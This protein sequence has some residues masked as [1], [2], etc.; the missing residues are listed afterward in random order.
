MAQYNG[1]NSFLSA[2]S[3]RI[4]TIMNET[5]NLLRSIALEICYLN[6]MI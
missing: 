1:L 3:Q 4:V 2:P 6:Y 5:Q